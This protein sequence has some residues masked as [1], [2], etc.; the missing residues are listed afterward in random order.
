MAQVNVTLIG[1]NR[2]NASFG[3]A[4]RKLA[5]VPNA[6]HQFAVTGSDENRATLDKAKELGAIDQAIRNMDMAVENADLVFISMP[7]AVMRDVLKAISP[8]LKRGAVV[9]DLSLLKLPAIEWADQYFRKSADGQ[10]EAFLVGVTPVI[11]PAYLSDPRTDIEAA[12]ADLFDQGTLV[13]A[14]SP[15]CPPDAVRLVTDLAGLMGLKVHFMDPAEHDGL[16]ASMEG[17][18]LLLQVALFRTLSTSPGW[19]DLKR[20]SNP[21]FVL[22]TYRLETDDAEDFGLSIEQNRANNVRVLESL[23]QT[24][25][26]MIG[27]LKTGDQLT[28][29]ELFSDSA[30]KYAKWQNDRGRNKWGDEGELPRPEVPRIFGGLPGL[31]PS[32]KGKKQDG[33]RR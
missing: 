4:M 28:I 1:L 30:S 17:L 27:V 3:L 23:V 29:A 10:P 9:V 31:L 5:Q 12:Q 15:M 21:A 8:V 33:S 11:N 20:L 26:E 14:P 7:F 25:N 24:L 16:I 2:L 6:R 32:N 19:G 22:A 18:P 13:L